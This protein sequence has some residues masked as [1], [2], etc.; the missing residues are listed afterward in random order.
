MP[1]QNDAP[2]EACSDE[3]ALPAERFSIRHIVA[4]PDHHETAAG[5]RLVFDRDLR[6]ASVDLDAFDLIGWNHGVEG[7]E[8]FRVNLQTIE[9]NRGAASAR[10]RVGLQDA[11]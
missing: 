4:R 7:I 8:V 6:T 10:K 9:Q 2:N 5:A 1:N 3:E 11:R